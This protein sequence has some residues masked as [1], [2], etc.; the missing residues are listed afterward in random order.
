MLMV[1]NTV[2]LGKAMPGIGGGSA[3]PE[4][5]SELPETGEEG[6]LY[7]VPSGVTRDGYSIFQMFSWH[8]DEWVAVGAFD[9]GIDADNIVY[10]DQIA[11]YAYTPTTLVAG[12]NVTFTQQPPSQQGIDSNCLACWHFDTGFDDVVSNIT[13]S[14]ASGTLSTDDSNQM[15]A[16][17]FGAG[18]CCYPNSSTDYLSASNATAISKIQTAKAVTYDFWFYDGFLTGHFPNFNVY[19]NDNEIV[20]I[21]RSGT[22]VS[23]ISYY[24]GGSWVTASTSLGQVTNGWRHL[25]IQKDYDANLLTVFLDGTKIIDVSASWSST[26]TNLIKISVLQY[27]GGAFDELRISD[28]IRYT[29]DFTPPTAAYQGI[30]DQPDIFQVNS[31]VPYATSSRVGGIRQ[32]FDSAT[33]TLT[34]ITEDL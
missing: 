28:K 13:L 4:Y 21:A 15:S 29:A 9:V 20:S 10:K 22:D 1:S 3:R 17:K 6:V 30:T 23:S 12:D 34:I 2:Y 26:M 5:V 25:A 27:N 7:M 33:G 14:P 19:V 8:N 18:A 11:Q 31:V 32:S 16:P 24:V